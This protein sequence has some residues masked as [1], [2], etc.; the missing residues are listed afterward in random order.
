MT[1]W[2]IFRHLVDIT[3]DTVA[4]IKP[5]V[6]EYVLLFLNSFDNNIELLYEEEHNYKILF[7]DVFN[8]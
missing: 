6:V 4:R 7:L 3:A 5:A 2:I 8:F 1:A